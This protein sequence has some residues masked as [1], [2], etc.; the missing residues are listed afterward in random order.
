MKVVVTGA[1]G[2]I[3]T[4]LLRRWSHDGSDH[5][6]VG[7]CRRP[8]TTAG[9]PY[10]RARWLSVDVSDPTVEDLL[11][12]A[13]AGA[14]RVVH[15]AWQIQPSRDAEQ[16]RRTNVE[17]SWRVVDAAR[18]AGVRHVVHLSS[19]AA[20]QPHPGRDP[21]DE[22]W[23]STGLTASTYSRHKATVEQLLDR[24]DGPLRVARLRPPLVGQWVAAGELQ[25]FAAGPPLPVP[26]RRVPL[27]LVL[28]TGLTMQA[29]HA[30]DVASAI[31]LAL[32][33]GA[34]RAY[35]VAGDGVLSARDLARALG[36]AGA[37]EVPR[38]AVRGGLTLAHR[39]RLSPLEPAW[40]DLALGMPVVDSARARSELAW[41]PTRTAAQVIEEVARGVH[42]R[43]GSPSRA[44]RPRQLA[45]G[46]RLP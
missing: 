9:A 4:A 3:G 35:N 22:S 24:L 28:P 8:P 18:R 1:S 38:L 23:P 29:V 43:A 41:R 16:M 11:D 30:D 42:E 6:V 14:D 20:Y 32:Q 25:R 27:P 39:L 44:L 46:R 26:T 45:H 21:V 19:V 40:L 33:H 34:A 13:M 31:D 10:D 17:G 15:L 2:N 37:F 5:E 7:L 36:A 12:D